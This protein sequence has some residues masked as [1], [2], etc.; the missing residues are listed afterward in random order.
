MKTFLLT[1][2]LVVA[3]C[4]STPSTDLAQDAPMPNDSVMDRYFEHLSREE[5]EQA[6]KSLDEAKVTD[7][8]IF[9]RVPVGGRMVANAFPKQVLTDYVT[10]IQ[11]EL[12]K[13]EK[14]CLRPADT[15]QNRIDSKQCFDANHDLNSFEEFDDGRF[16]M[17]RYVQ[18]GW[19]SKR[20]AKDEGLSTSPDCGPI[21][22]RAIKTG[23]KNHE[24]FITTSDFLNL[25]AK[26]RALALERDIAA[27]E[28]KRE[29]EAKAVS[30]ASRER[31]AKYESTPEYIRDQ[32]CRVDSVTKTTQRELQ[33]HKSAGEKSGFVDATR[34][35]QL[36]QMLASE[37]NARRNFLKLY[38]DKT[39]KSPDLTKCYA[40]RP[41]E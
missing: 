2:L 3:G 15:H 31:F 18:K 9:Y 1:I 13:I 36:G 26:K 28:S 35:A 24:K 33:F 7:G 37:E 27:H 22:Y 12:I 40:T 17:G 14:E 19:L 34:M 21:G 32:I 29:L 10:Y 39:G 23:I 16:D 4:S 20:C 25:Y 30:E 11:Q 8:L 6:K 41:K 5:F 38:R